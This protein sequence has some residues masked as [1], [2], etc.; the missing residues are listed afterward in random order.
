MEEWEV[1]VQRGREYLVKS[2]IG[3]LRRK[4]N[5][6]TQSWAESKIDSRIR[7][8]GNKICTREENGSA[9][10]YVLETRV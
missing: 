7:K 5:A 8:K 1:V 3:V 4:T 2:K 6:R 9:R 10:K